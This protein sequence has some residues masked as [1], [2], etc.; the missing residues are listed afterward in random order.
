MKMT[1]S[2]FARMTGV[3]VRTLHHYDAIGLLKPDFV[4]AQTG[5]RYYTQAALARMQEILFYRELEFSLKAI[6]EILAAPQYNKREAL[7]QQKQLLLLKKQRLERIIAA[8]ECAEE[9]E[10]IVD[11]K[12]FDRRE[13]DAYR[14]E[15]RQRW[16]GTAAYQEHVIKTAA[17][18][19]E[20]WDTVAGEIEAILAA[21]AAAK[22]SGKAADSEQAAVLAARLQ[23]Y[24]TETQYACTDVILAALGEMYIADE[25]FTASIDRHGDGTA[26]Y[27]HAAIQAYC[28]K[29]A[30]K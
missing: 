16:G 12:A 5:Y 18:T 9:G 4:D 11:F 3:S 10:A 24:I 17:Y 30:E 25:R 26:A 27:I 8:L 28:N 7:I 19:A 6:R 2:E 15:A 20:D 1:V 21:F 29:K 22:Q 13:L 14:A 23:R